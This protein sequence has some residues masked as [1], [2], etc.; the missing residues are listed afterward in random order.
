MNYIQKINSC[1]AEYYDGTNA[2][3]LVG[4]YPFV[5]IQDRE[6]GILTV[7]TMVGVKN[8]YKSQYLMISPRIDVINKKD[9]ES[10]WS[11]DKYHIFNNYINTEE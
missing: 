11:T 4:L 8:L 7:D 10:Y 1:E 6:K 5:K 3:T 9:F 2:D